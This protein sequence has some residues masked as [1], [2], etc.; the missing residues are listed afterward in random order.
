MPLEMPPLQGPATA[1]PGIGPAEAAPVFPRVRF[2]DAARRKLHPSRRSGL[3]PLRLDADRL[4]KTL[5]DEHRRHA[6][7]WQAGLG[8]ADDT[9]RAEVAAIADEFAGPPPARLAPEREA[10]RAAMLGAGNPKMRVG[11]RP[12]PVAPPYNWRQDTIGDTAVDFWVS[13]EGPLFALEAL[14]RSGA[15]GRVLRALN[16]GEEAWLEARPVEMA[17]ATAPAA[18]DSLRRHLASAPTELYEATRERASALRATVGPRLRRALAY[19]FPD[20]PGWANAD[21]AEWV[22]L[23]ERSRDAGQGSLPFPWFLLASA[24]DAALVDRALERTI[25]NWPSSDEFFWDVVAN[26]GVRAEPFLRR[27]AAQSHGSWRSVSL[28]PLALIESETVAAFMAGCVDA[29]DEEVRGPATSY[30]KRLP[31]LAVPALLARV[32]PQASSGPTFSLL[33]SLTRARPDLLDAQVPLAGPEMRPLL[34]R[35]RAV[36]EQRLPEAASSEL[37][38]VLVQPPWTEGRKAPKKAWKVIALDPLPGTEAVHLDDTIRRPVLEAMEERRRLYD[39][40]RD[41]LIAR[42]EAMAAARPEQAFGSHDLLPD[43]VALRLLDAAQGTKATYFGLS[44]PQ[45]LLLRFGLRVLPHLIEA[46]PPALAGTF[47]AVES[48]RVAPAMAHALS[49]KQSRAVAA[50]WLNRFP[51]AAAIGLVPVAVGETGKPRERAA[52]ALR[53]LAAAHAKVVRGVAARYGMEAARA[54]EEILSD[55]GTDT[56]VR[57]PVMPA[58]WAAAGLPRP[59]LGAGTRALPVDA[60]ENLGRLL[61]LSSLEKPHPGLVAVRA[62]CDA[63]SLAAFAWAL[64]EQWMAAGAPMDEAWAFVALGLLGDDAAARRLAPLIRQWPPAGHHARAVLGLEVLGA[65]GTEV[66]LMHVHGVAQ[67]ARHAGIQKKAREIIGQIAAARGLSEEELADRLVPD[68][69]L[70]PDGSKL[71]DFGPRQ[72]RVGFDER[73]R[74]YVLD[75]TGQARAELPKPGK[76]DDKALAKAA[77]EAWKALKK[78][79]AVLGDQELLRLEIAMCRKRRWP[80]ATFETCLAGHPLLGHV[81]RRL[82]WATCDADGRLLATFRMTAAGPRDERGQPVQLAPDSRVGLPHPL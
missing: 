59:T 31:E 29:T 40:E 30:L 78:D 10:V 22:A 28:G 49:L 43:D 52:A 20:H 45:G 72:F 34:D 37:P 61:A 32:A 55:D 4:W 77:A 15:H 75:G 38:A 63:P 60:V 62:S 3:S 57:A 82:V 2:T 26:V 74:P 24:D 13:R 17:R 35:L 80:V 14:V 16:P 44:G 51:E 39:H 25:G 65:I 33:S 12:V 47:A 50:L 21:L 54:V 66:A 9:Y 5:A 1:D 46:L 42:V 81:V 27:L 56:P 8:R 41:A 6:A 19:A 58:F 23:D 79:V 53:T 64:F 68:L 48:P 73:L 69:D 36:T 11:D 70:E 67:R 76:A 18:W 7:A 71:L